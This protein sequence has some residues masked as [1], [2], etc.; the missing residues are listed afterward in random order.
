MSKLSDFFSTIDDTVENN[1]EKTWSTTRI[2]NEVDQAVQESL[3]N[4]IVYSIALG[5]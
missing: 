1:D 2:Q 3:D 4:A 5:G